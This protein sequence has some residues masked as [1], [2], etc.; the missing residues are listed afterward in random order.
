MVNGNCSLQSWLDIVFCPY[1][2]PESGYELALLVALV[3]AASSIVNILEV[4]S[5]FGLGKRGF[6]PRRTAS[7]PRQPRAKNSMGQSLPIAHRAPLLIFP[8][9]HQI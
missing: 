1:H 2:L 3:V 7:R 8:F 4:F 5:Q 6:P 9:I